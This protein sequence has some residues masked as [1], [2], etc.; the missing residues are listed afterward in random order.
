M[1]PAT[2]PPRSSSALV[3]ALV[4]ACRPDLSREPS[5]PPHDAPSAAPATSQSSAPAPAKSGRPAAKQPAATPADPEAGRLAGITAAHNRHRA[6]LGIAPLTW[7]P[8][9]ARYAQKWADK[10]QKQRCALKHRPRSGTDAQRHGENLYAGSGQAATPEQVVDRWVA[11]VADYDAKTGRCRGVCGHYTQVVWR[12][13]QRLGCA[14]VTCGDTEVWV[15]NYDPPGNFLG[16]K[17]Y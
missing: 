13:S 8:E 9:L 3:V 7:S 10:L 16:Q 11:E 12:D 6:E 5:S 1:S 2:S 15:C 17:P 4:L 14:M